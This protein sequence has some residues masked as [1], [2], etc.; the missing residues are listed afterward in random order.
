MSRALLAIGAFFTAAFFLSVLAPGCAN[1]V[2]PGGGPRDTL[3]P[4]LVSAV[5]RDSAVNVTE[6][7]LVLQ[8]NEFVELKSPAEK[9]L[10]APYPKQMPSFEYR[11]RTVTVR[12][13][14]SLL[15]NTTYVIDFGDAIVDLNE[16]N[17]AKNFRYIFSTGAAID[18]NQLTGR[19]ILAETGKTDSTLFALLHTRRQDST[20]ALETP[21]YVAR[22]DANGYFRFTNL[23]AGR[24]YVYALGEAD[25]NKRYNLPTE[26]F[27]FLDTA[28]AVSA[29]TPPVTLYAY[30]AE[31]EKKKEPAARPAE[32]KPFAYRANIEG[33][34]VHLYDSLELRYSHPLAATDSAAVQLLSDSGRSQQPFRLFYDSVTY[35]LIVAARWQ[36]GATYQLVLGRGYATDTAGTKAP[37]NDTLSFRIRAEKEY[38]SIR[39]RLRNADTAGRPV[40]LFYSGDQIA[41]SIPFTG[42]EIYRRYFM[43]GSY[44]LAILFDTN[45]NGVWDPGDYFAKPRRQPERVRALNKAFTVK[46]NWDNELEIEL[47]AEQ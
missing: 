32:K 4:V 42:R 45:G 7:K 3:P 22:V 41:H 46:E 44:Q 21:P 24:Y 29:N 14:D 43:P 34:A 2:P 20:V 39:I 37:G 12:L 40:L 19:I 16:G 10:V 9:I 25:G 15:P 36:P 28:I 5:P 8:F 13:K 11:L 18:T 6:R 33:G 30:A 35:R 38:G 26:I 17:P 1:I 47:T 23:P 27:A 31:K